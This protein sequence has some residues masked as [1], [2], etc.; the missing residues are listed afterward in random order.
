MIAETATTRPYA[1]VTSMLSR[2][3]RET[4]SQTQEGAQYI[5]LN[6]ITIRKANFNLLSNYQ[7]NNLKQD[8]ENRLNSSNNEKQRNARRIH[9]RN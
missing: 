7:H 9:S 5:R 4:A 2:N 3:G 6:Y 1:C 8:K